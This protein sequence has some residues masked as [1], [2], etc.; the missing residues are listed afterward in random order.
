MS[1]S[2]GIP[3]ETGLNL[4]HDRAS[5]AGSFPHS[6]LGYDRQSVDTYVREIEQQLSAAKQLLPWKR[7]LAPHKRPSP[8]GRVSW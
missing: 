3:E 8:G 4:F 7:A 6:M 5:A 2:Q 1:N